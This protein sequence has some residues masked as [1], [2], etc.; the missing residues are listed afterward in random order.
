[1]HLLACMLARIF[2]REQ[3]VSVWS[4]LIDERKRLLQSA[5]TES[6]VA[7]QMSDLTAARIEI[8]RGQLDEWDGSAR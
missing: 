5:V 6:E 4:E 3:A 1:M 7:F 2:K 8:S